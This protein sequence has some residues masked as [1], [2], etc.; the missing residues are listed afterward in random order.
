LFIQYQIGFFLENHE[1]DLLMDRE[2]RQENWPGF[3][4]AGSF[5]TG[6]GQLASQWREEKTE[7]RAGVSFS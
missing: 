7:K 3:F 5:K 4:S 1:K 2:P 6:E